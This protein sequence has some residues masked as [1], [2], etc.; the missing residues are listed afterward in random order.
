MS[1]VAGPALGAGCCFD[2]TAIRLRAEAGEGLR[3]G[4]RVLGTKRLRLDMTSAPGGRA[5]R[6][7]QYTVCGT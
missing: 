1:L 2:V 3:N 5:G 7:L 4:L 6:V